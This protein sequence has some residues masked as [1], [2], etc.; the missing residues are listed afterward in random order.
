M[1]VLDWSL[2]ALFAGSILLGILRGGSKEV[3]GLGGWLGG[4]VLAFLGAPLLA[5]FLSGWILPATLRWLAA[6]IVIFIAVRLVA[7]GLGKVLSELIAAA[8]LGVFDKLIGFIFGTFRAAVIALIVTFLAMTT[9]LPST[10]LWQMSASG[11]P[12]IQIVSALI[13]LLPPDIQRWVQK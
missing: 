2:L 8:K 7:W 5:P 13:P 9:A 10:A 12:L 1:N 4:L 3:L 11:T 6:F